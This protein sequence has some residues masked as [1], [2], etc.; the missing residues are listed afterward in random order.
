M[1][2]LPLT[3]HIYYSHT[4]SRFLLC[5]SLDLVAIAS[6]EI[7]VHCSLSHLHCDFALLLDYLGCLQCSRRDDP[8]KPLDIRV[9]ALLQAAPKYQRKRSI[10][11]RI[12]LRWIIIILGGRETVEVFDLATFFSV[13]ATSSVAATSAVS[14]RRISL[15]LCFREIHRSGF[16][17]SREATQK[18]ICFSLI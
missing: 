11:L 12:R 4:S 15:A 17:I 18:R 8:A 16:G 5:F 9:F 10:G 6:Q 13:S 2:G 3:T 7:T 14:S 1:V